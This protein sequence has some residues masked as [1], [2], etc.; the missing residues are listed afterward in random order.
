MAKLDCAFTCPNLGRLHK[1]VAHFQGAQRLFCHIPQSSCGRLQS[2][3]VIVKRIAAIQSIYLL[4]TIIFFALWSEDTHGFSVVWFMSLFTRHAF[5]WPQIKPAL[6]PAE[7]TGR[8]EKTSALRKN[9]RRADVQL[10]EGGW[11]WMRASV[12]CRAENAK[13]M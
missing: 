1:F 7:R 2:L 12:S 11:P 10:H 6:L 13:S 8:R 9:C 5:P 3:F 4:F